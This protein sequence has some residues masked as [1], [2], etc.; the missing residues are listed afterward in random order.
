MDKPFRLFVGEMACFGYSKTHNMALLAW[1]F[2]FF[3][4]FPEYIPFNTR[5]I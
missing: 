2:V 3:K 5:F 1:K 4:S